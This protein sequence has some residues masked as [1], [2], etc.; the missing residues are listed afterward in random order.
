MK[1]FKCTNLSAT[2]IEEIEFIVKHHNIDLHNLSKITLCLVPDGSLKDE[3]SLYRSSRFLKITANSLNGI[4]YGLCELK[5][6]GYKQVNLHYTARLSERAVMID[7]G[8]KYFSV[9]FFKKLIEEM[10]VNKF[11][12]LQLHLSDNEGFRIESELVPEAVSSEFLTKK[13]IREIV[14][15]AHKFGIQIIPELDSPGHLKQVLSKHPQFQLP[16][17]NGLNISDESAIEWFK[18]IL[19]EYFELF[20]DSKYF[21]IGGDEFVEFDKINDYPELVAYAKNNIDTQA[22]GIDTYLHYLNQIAEL[23]TQSGFVPRVWNDGLFRDEYPDPV[24]KL[25]TDF[26]I[27]YWTK[28]NSKMAP[29]QTF[30]DHGYQVINYNDGYFYHVLGEAASYQYPTVKK[31]ARWQINEFPEYQYV[32]DISNIKGQSMNVWCDIPDAQTETEV[33][34]ALTKYMPIIHGKEWCVR[35][36]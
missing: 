28:W 25:S 3:F 7:C 34:H 26:E 2:E 19:R 32:E 15:Y 8:R 17:S 5:N 11:N 33:L 1:P 6:T 18:Q 27:T 20:A 9:D 24:V 23:A 31:I 4:K 36:R 30:I 12:T 10:F 16:N 35:N 13:E 29:V 21:H 22:T 14:A